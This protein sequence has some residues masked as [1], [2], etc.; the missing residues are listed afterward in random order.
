MQPFPLTVSTLDAMHLATF[1]F[2]RER[3][4]KPSLATFDER[5]RLAAIALEFPLALP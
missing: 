4:Q 3:G 2:L 5:M 1:D